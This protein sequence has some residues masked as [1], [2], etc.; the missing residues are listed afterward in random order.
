MLSLLVN[1]RETP[2]LL[3]VQSQL[4]LKL[5]RRQHHRRKTLKSLLRFPCHFFDDPATSV[6]EAA[7]ETLK[8]LQEA[9]IPINDLRDLA[10]RLGGKDFCTRNTG[11]SCARLPNW[12]ST[13]ILGYKC[14]Y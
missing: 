1:Q 7:F 11:R 8:I 12:R 6:E 13:E 4:L 10:I 9:Q 3:K 2:F 5:P 14:R